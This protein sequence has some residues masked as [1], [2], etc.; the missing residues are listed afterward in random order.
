MFSISL[1]FLKPSIQDHVSARASLRV[2]VWA[3]V[4]VRA[5]LFLVQ[6]H[7]QR[8]KLMPRVRMRISV[9]IKL[10]HRI[11][12]SSPSQTLQMEEFWFKLGLGFFGA[13]VREVV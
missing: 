12:L 9:R 7:L 13:R 4:S 1:F 10:L 11:T 2:R 6:R 5:Y 3:Q 8:D